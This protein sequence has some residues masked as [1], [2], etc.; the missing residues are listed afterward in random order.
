VGPAVLDSTQAYTV[1]IET[2]DATGL[3]ALTN[4][5]RLAPLPAAQSPEVIYLGVLKGG[6]K[7][8][9]QFV[10]PVKVTGKLAT[11]LTCLPS[12]D[13]CQIVELSPGQAMSLEPSSDPALVATF[14]FE[15]K[16][17]GAA[18]FSSS[19]AA[20]SA[21]SAVSSAGQT[22]LPLL[23]STASKTLR[24]DAKL[25]ALVHQN[26]PGG[27]SSGST[28]ASGASGSTG[29]SGATGSTAATGSSG[30]TGTTGDQLAG[31]PVYTRAVAVSDGPA[32]G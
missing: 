15:L 9:F 10:D 18:N 1:D 21:R 20:D 27:G 4:V 30:S 17:I 26:A 24:F 31:A 12:T 13:D 25:G 22:L 5:V 8:A 3:H 14:T 32:A 6:M 2:K 11:T 23:S 28:G 29:S 19:A 7:A 16:S